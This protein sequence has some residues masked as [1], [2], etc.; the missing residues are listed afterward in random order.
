MKIFFSILVVVGVSW[1][2]CSFRS[3]ERDRVNALKQTSAAPAVPAADNDGAVVIPWTLL[4]QTQYTP[5]EKPQF[6]AALKAL[7]GRRATI[8]GAVFSIKALEK[9]GKTKG[10]LLMP[11]AKLNCC[12]TAC[13]SDPRTMLFVSCQNNPML[14]PKA[15][16]TA[17]VTGRL[18][19]SSDDSAWGLFTLEDANAE[20]CK[21]VAEARP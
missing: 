15:R 14:V 17:T 11:L 7:E 5:G 13:A 10:A 21:P 8:T 19:L 16:S 18:T 9:D 4:E 2:V 1:N 6:P 20:E 3:I 12:G